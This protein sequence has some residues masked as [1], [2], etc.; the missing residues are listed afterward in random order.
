MSAWSGPPW[1]P[2]RLRS[3]RMAF[4]DCCLIAGDELQVKVERPQRSEDVRP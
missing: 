3:W 1:Q 4:L 2:V